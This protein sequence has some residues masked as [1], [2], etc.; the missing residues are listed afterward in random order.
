MLRPPHSSWCNHL[1]LMTKMLRYEAVSTGIIS[2]QAVIF[3][4][5]CCTTFTIRRRS[6]LLQFIYFW[7]VNIFTRLVGLL[8]WGIGP[9]QGLKTWHHKDRNVRSYIPAE[10]RTEGSERTKTLWALDWRPLRLA[11]ENP[12]N[13][14]DAA[15]V[16]FERECTNA[17]RQ[18][19]VMT[20]FC[21]VVANICGSSVWNLFHVTHRS[22]A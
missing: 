18:I 3:K 14:V 7:S 11:C 6:G 5:E 22:G 4:D 8:V 9:S 17:R 12:H 15:L 10:V 19:P 21:T 1:S 20:K 2:Q 13:E 16:G